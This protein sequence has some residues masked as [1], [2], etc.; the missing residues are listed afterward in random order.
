M[1]AEVAKKWSE[2]ATSS[3]SHN[4]DLKLSELGVKEKRKFRYTAL[5]YAVSNL[6]TELMI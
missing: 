2:K 1:S 5:G 4:N 6:Q 3:S